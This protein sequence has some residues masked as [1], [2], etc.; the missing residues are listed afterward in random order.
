MRIF[1]PNN[2]ALPCLIL[3]IALI[4]LTRLPYLSLGIFDPDEAVGVMVGQAILEGGLPY[5]DAVD[6]RGPLSYLFFAAISAASSGLNLRAIH[7]I[8]T[9]LVVAMTF[10]L[11]RMAQRAF[12]T[13]IA[14]WTA[15]LFSVLSCSGML[16]DLM[17]A[18]TEWLMVLFTLIGLGI[19]VQ[20]EDI[21]WD[22]ALLGGVF[23]GIAALS[24]QVAL[25][26]WLMFPVSMGLLALWQRL[27][28]VVAIRRVFWAGTGFALPLLGVMLLYVLLGEWEAFYAH[29]WQY[30][31][32]IYMP[33]LGLGARVRNTWD[34]LMTFSLGKTLLLALPLTGVGILIRKAWVKSEGMLPPAQLMLGV[35]ALLALA[36]SFT[37]GRNFG[38][39]L[40]QAFP[41]LALMGG[42]TLGYVQEEAFRQLPVLKPLFVM[43][44][45]LAT[46]YPPFISY[47]MYYRSWLRA[48][49]N[50]GIEQLIAYL[51]P[52]GEAGKSLFVWGFSPSY[53]PLT[54]M[55][56]ASRYLY[57]TFQTGVVPI[58][59][60]HLEHTDAFVM[61]GSW[62]S[63]MEDLE[64]TPPDF[65]IDAAKD[66]YSFMEWHPISRYPLLQDWVDTHY[67][68]DSVYH[69]QS[70]GHQAILYRR[71]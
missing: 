20:N 18:H 26:D 36:G 49:E 68:R 62:D 55:R 50:T 40:I 22:R 58:E 57:T 56:P 7:V 4:L 34:L 32:D 8:L 42:I 25:W 52:E 23:L 64:A 60:T 41:G 44:I 53:Y 51:E 43:L 47:E 71:K 33:V 21:S 27:P 29:A 67:I 16:K 39:Y 28:W 54:G 46:L 10:L 15:I 12:S 59:N 45:V 63:L 24:K 2:Q 35:W 66:E 61:P 31:I 14:C 3:A 69:A 17:A 65:V 48:R 11:Y 30:N 38:H 37:G 5:V 6:H 9:V 70:P 1:T 19:W 13:Q